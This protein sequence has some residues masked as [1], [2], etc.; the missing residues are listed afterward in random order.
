MNGFISILG[1]G[2]CISRLASTASFLAIFFSMGSGFLAGAT[3]DLSPSGSLWAV[4]LEEEHSASDARGPDGS[5]VGTSE[6]SQVTF[7]LATSDRLRFPQFQL[8]GL[9]HPERN[10]DAQE[11]PESARRSMVVQA[12]PAANSD[13]VVE[14][15]EWS[16]ESLGVESIHFS[17]ELTKGDRL[18]L[19]NL[20]LQEQ[21]KSVTPP[22]APAARGRDARMSKTLTLAQTRTKPAS[23]AKTSTFEQTASE[24]DA[25]ELPGSC[26]LGIEHEFM[27]P[28]T[29]NQ[30]CP[31]KMEWLSKS[32]NSKGWIKL[33]GASYLPTLTL[34]PA[35]SKGPTVLL[36]EG[37][38]ATLYM[39]K[40]IKPTKGMGIV[41]G[42]L[43]EGYKI[44]FAGRS[45]DT[46][47]FKSKDQEYFAILNV[48][49]GAGVLELVSEKSQE[50]NSTV[51]VPV[52]EDV[53]TYLDLSAPQL[54]DIEV[55][56][57]KSGMPNDPEVVGLTVGLSTQN[58]LQAITRSDGTAVLQKVRQVS[59]FPQYVDI[60]SRQDQEVGYVYRFQ[61]GEPDPSGRH[62]VHQ[63]EGNS[64]YRWLSQVKQGLSDQGAMVVGTHQ[65]SRF[66]GFREDYFA[67]VEPLTSKFGLE[68][69]TY[70]I[71][72]NGEI[73]S[74]EPLEGDLPRFMSVQV[75]EGLSQ[76]RLKGPEGKVLK[77]DLFPVSP[78]VIH[79]I[80]P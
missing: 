70:S 63:I 9:F 30:I 61:L 56:V 69:L 48:E 34:H 65:R 19:T 8:S 71:L 6:S 7:D 38:I 78:R 76:V 53:V 47:Y 46:E 3:L 11:K 25:P 45:E 58:G 10:L 22:P 79:V 23:L 16:N 60:S 40:G 18:L 31:K 73:S 33:E 28:G 32:W 12:T 66:D 50:L 44:D 42:R 37:Q 21:L 52:L 24:A 68:P 64:L 29:D 2:S 51:F 75:A 43:P 35:P 39:G 5:I 27:R 15:P 80:S 26:G 49:P 13:R 74:D 20:L 62:V 41:L 55:R 17:P 14:S 36:D 77:S 67:E 1:L 72:W 57:V 4:E 59:G 54:V